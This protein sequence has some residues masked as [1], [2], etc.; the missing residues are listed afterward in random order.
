MIPTQIASDPVLALGQELLSALKM[1]EPA[2]RFIEELAA[3]SWDGLV[4]A[5]A[6]DPRKNAFWINLYN[7]FNLYKM[8]NAPTMTTSQERMKHF[9]ARDIRIAGELFSLIDIENGI[10]RRSKPIWGLGYITHPF[11]SRK[12]RQLRVKRPDSRVH[13]ALNCGALSCPPIRF[14]SAEAIDAQ[15]ELAT[16]AYLL[17][18]VEYDEEEA[19]DKLLVTSLF[20]MYPGDFGGKGG[21]RKFVRQYREDLPAK[22]LKW[23]YKKW[24]WTPFLTNFS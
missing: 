19:P 11:P 4:A 24:N 6:D 15:L 23:T 7:A 18:E 3:L 8:R 21:A 9:L 5:L 10:L 20:R 12:E 2:E 13:F 1:E 17:T 14:Y 16:K 22:R